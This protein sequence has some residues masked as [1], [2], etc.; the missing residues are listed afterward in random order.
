MAGMVPFAW[1]DPFN[2]DDQLTEEERMIRDAA[3]GFAQDNLQPRVIGAFA[4][5]GHGGIRGRC[6][7]DPHQP[8]GHGLAGYTRPARA[9][10]ALAPSGLA[11]GC[12]AELAQLLF[13]L[14][15]ALFVLDEQQDGLAIAVRERAQPFEHVALPTR[16]TW[17]GVV[18]GM[19]Q[20]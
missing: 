11:I 9:H 17:C 12:A 7:G 5:P 14:L 15:D 6:G 13:Q 3:R 16:I 19:A 10:P 4:D 8:Q 18:L 1:E 2:L 20:Q